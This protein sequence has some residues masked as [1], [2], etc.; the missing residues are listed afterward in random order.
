MG[1]LLFF[2]LFFSSFFSLVE[3]V[4]ENVHHI[5]LFINQCCFIL[6]EKKNHSVFRFF[7]FFLG[8]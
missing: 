3:V 1:Q 6:G 7:G 5:H 2:F 4:K 8:E